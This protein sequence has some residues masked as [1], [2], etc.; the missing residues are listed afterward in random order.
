M[1][2]REPPKKIL[3]RR[4]LRRAMER[5]DAHKLK[6]AYI[7]AAKIHFVNMWSN[8][9]KKIDPI[10]R[11]RAMQMVEECAQDFAD[12]A[13]RGLALG[14]AGGKPEPYRMP[15]RLQLAR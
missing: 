3:S 5:N 12:Q 2:V 11:S 14:R 4:V 8:V 15:E 13:E 1:P 10:D 6:A 9:L 7:E